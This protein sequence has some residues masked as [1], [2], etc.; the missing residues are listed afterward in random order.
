MTVHAR[1]LQTGLSVYIAGSTLLI[2]SLWRHHH[3]LHPPDGM[4]DPF[5]I[6]L[7]DACTYLSGMYARGGHLHSGSA[8]LLI[9]Q[10]TGL[11]AYI[12]D[13][14][15]H[16]HHEQ[17]GGV[18]L[19]LH[20]RQARTDC[21]KYSRCVLLTGYHLVLPLGDHSPGKGLWALRW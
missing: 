1:M 2:F 17:T 7:W 16:T 6:T 12:A 19:R 10:W 21:C 9:M 18:L 20:N 11:S 14:P 3:R 15:V 4:I 13:R 8:A 5:P